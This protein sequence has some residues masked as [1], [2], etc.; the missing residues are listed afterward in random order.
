MPIL[1][2]PDPKITTSEGIVAF[3]GDL[4]PESLQLAYRQGIFPWPIE[5][6][7]LPWFCP[8]NR[9]I[10]DLNQIHIPRSLAKYRRKVEFRYTIDKEFNQV[11][12]ACALTKR[13]GQKGTWITAEIQKAY[14]LFHELGH[15]HSVE[16]WKD[17]KLIGGMYGV[18]T[19]GAFAGESMFHL[20]SNASKL[21]LLHL[22][23]HLKSR[24][25]DWI[26]IQVLT[27]HMKSLG[28]FEI[29]RSQFLKKLANT[30]RQNL[31]LF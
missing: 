2:F 1:S 26:D 15:A 13:P 8:P 12:K 9:A 31:C 17:E 23:E 25:L 30:Q 20:E 29:P 16:V 10:L 3:G 4:H 19:G 6:L 27:P 14:I 7:P 24:G 28:A 22:C 18:D 21:A 5:G 11:I